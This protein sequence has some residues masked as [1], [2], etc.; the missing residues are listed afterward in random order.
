MIIFCLLV[1]FANFANYDNGELHNA[2]IIFLLYEIKMKVY[3]K[4]EDY[5]KYIFQCYE[6]P[7]IFVIFAGCN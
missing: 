1:I 2:K 6:I 4:F 3:W 5:V 7:T